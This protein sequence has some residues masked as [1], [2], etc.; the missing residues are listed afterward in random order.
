MLDVIS[1]NF[2][3]YKLYEKLG[4]EHFSGTIHLVYEK[5][6]P[7]NV[8]SLPNEYEFNELHP[9]DWR[10]AYELAEQI[11]PENVRTY[12]P[13][14]QSD[15]KEPFFLRILEPLMGTKGGRGAVRHRESGQ[16]VAAGSYEYRTRS[17]GVNGISLR[18]DPAHETAGRFLAHWLASKTQVLAPGLKLEISVPAWQ[19]NLAQ[20]ARDAGFIDRYIYHTMALRIEK[21]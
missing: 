11:T 20:I 14:K 19:E 5:D 18:C 6:E 9:R 3:A 21:D 1:E 2:P 4:F 8:S 16:V 17:G 13:V 15:Y 12:R 10:P 7:I